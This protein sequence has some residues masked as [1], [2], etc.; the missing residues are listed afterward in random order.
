MTDWKD[1]A[2]RKRTSVLE[3]IPQE[4]R[5]PAPPSV[6]VQRDVTGSFVQQYLSS[7]EIEIT[8]TDAVGIVSKARNGDWTAL[9]I[10]QAFCHRA[11]VAHQLVPSYQTHS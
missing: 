11:A 6:S 2:A 10:A 4:W 8:E 7:K 1:I 3:L 9:E 5:I